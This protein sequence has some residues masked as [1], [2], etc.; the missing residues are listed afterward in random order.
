MSRADP[1]YSLGWN[2]CCE[3]KVRD[4]QFYDQIQD[5]GKIGMGGR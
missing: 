2:D 3:V 4:A 5:L 1:S